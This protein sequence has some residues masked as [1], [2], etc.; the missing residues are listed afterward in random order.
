MAKKLGM[1]AIFDEKGGRI[2]VTAV[3]VGPNVVLQRKTVETDGYAA[4][5]VGFGHKRPKLVSK[6]LAGHFQKAGLDPE[7]F[8][9]FVREIRLAAA[10]VERFT[11]GQELSMSFFA[12][13]D[14]VD[15]SGMS[16]G[17]GF[18]GVMKRYHF[19]GFPASHGTHEYF[20][21]AGSIGCRTTPGRVHK[22]KRMGGHMGA[23]NVTVQNLQVVRVVPEQRL[24]LIRG[25]VPGAKGSLVFVQA[26]VKQPAKAPEAAVAQ[27]A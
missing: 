23:D 3:E 24:L 8:P 1:T 18:Q 14:V 6:P 7:R 25:P 2:G 26:A 17:K 12:V 27:P 11:I 5:Q 19:S 21:H 16:K 4:L 22:G 20:R 9:R 13:G 15:V 10:D